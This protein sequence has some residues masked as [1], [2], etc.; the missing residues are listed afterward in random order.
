MTAE[1]ARH[2]DQAGELDKAIEYGLTAAHQAQ[3][4]YANEQALAGY[5]RVFELLSAV[6][7]DEQSDFDWQRFLTHKYMGE[8][9]TVVGRYDEAMA[10]L[11]SAWAVYP[12]AR[13]LAEVAGVVEHGLFIG[14]ARRVVLAGRSGV[15]VIEKA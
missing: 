15:R 2:F 6:E 13:R 9:L 7:L 5:N 4:A 14:L 11:E 3:L 1:L 12:A 10:H 8:V